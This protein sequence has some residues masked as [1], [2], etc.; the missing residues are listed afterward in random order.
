MELLEQFKKIKADFNL[1]IIGYE[2][3]K[4]LSKPIIVQMNIKSMEL[5]KRYNQKPKLI[6]FH[7][8]MRNFIV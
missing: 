5:A 4:K 3:A 8:L 7:N 2:D 1:G 6:K